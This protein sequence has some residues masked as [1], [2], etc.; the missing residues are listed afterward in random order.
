MKTIGSKALKKKSTV[1]FAITDGKA[2]EIPA[3]ADDTNHVKK[4]AILLIVHVPI[5]VDNINHVMSN[6]AT[7]RVSIE[8]HLIFFLSGEQR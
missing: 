4:D 6:S 5:V 7:S 8:R 2:N 1:S 3:F